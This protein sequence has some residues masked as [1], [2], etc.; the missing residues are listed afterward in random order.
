MAKQTGQLHRLGKFVRAFICSVSLLFGLFQLSNNLGILYY[1][2]YILE[3]VNIVIFSATYD[4]I[5][6]FVSAV[7]LCAGALLRMVRRGLTQTWQPR[8]LIVPYLV[9]AASF[10]LTPLS[11]QIAVVVGAI[12]ASLVVAQSIYFWSGDYFG[13][14]RVTA[15]MI[16]AGIALM[17]IPIEALALGTWIYNPFDYEVPFMPGGRWAFALADLNLFSLLYP[18]LYGLL[19]LFLF[20]WAWAPPVRTI[21][22][23]WRGKGRLHVGEDLEHGERPIGWQ[24]Q[25]L[26]LATI[27]AVSGFAAYYPYIRLSGEYLVGVD[28]IHYYNFLTRMLNEGA[29]AALVPDRPLFMI[30]LYGFQKITQ[31]PVEFIIRIMPIACAIA[32]V[33]S[34]F[35]LV[36]TG[37]GNPR[38]A[39]L[40]A[41]FSAFSFQVTAGMMGYFL[42]A[43]LAVAGAFVFFTFLLKSMESHTI[44]YILLAGL[45]SIAVLGVHP[46]T[47]LMMAA[48]LA[49]YILLTIIARRRIGR[50]AIIAMA[51]LAITAVALVPLILLTSL[52]ANGMASVIGVVKGLWQTL[53]SNLSFSKITLLLPSLSH[54]ADRW[55]GGAFGSPLVY[56]LALVGM[57]R[58]ADISKNF[59]RLLF[60]TVLIPALAILALVPGYEQLYYRIAYIC[61]VQIPAAVGLYWLVN[62]LTA[63]QPSGKEEMKSL[64]KS[65]MSNVKVL[66]Y[67]VFILV[68]FNYALRIADQVLIQMI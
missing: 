24:A 39:L 23:R 18:L 62:W 25:A 4:W 2:F 12:S 6:W 28:G 58:M 40:G 46:Y 61:P 68:L 55:V 7:G 37:T 16:M 57:V 38:L 53:M 67:T 32:L 33:V 17:L 11:S 27:S 59:H 36:K 21:W 49:A 29:L 10:A 34:V 3:T 54:M 44:L 5:I 45:A 9:L 30:L 65:S 60:S 35:W 1:H 41:L 52:G 22:L 14:R 66:I 43:W 63:R 13:E 20:S 51:P 15:A 8:W 56:V 48:I 26:V 64:P 47:W 42:A 50:E 19:L 31:L